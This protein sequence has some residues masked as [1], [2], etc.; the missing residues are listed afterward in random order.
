[1]TN[2]LARESH[3]THAIIIFFFFQI[4][5]A[6]NAYSVVWL[7]SAFIDIFIALLFQDKIEFFWQSS[8][9]FLDNCRWQ[10]SVYLEWICV[11]KNFKFCRILMNLHH[12]F[13]SFRVEKV[14]MNISTIHINLHSHFKAQIL[15]KKT[16]EITNWTEWNRKF[17][18]P[19][20]H[21]ILLRVS[22][23]FNFFCIYS[24]W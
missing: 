2:P 15:L 10:L 3:T 7:L 13:I 4:F 8:A 14:F 24:N 17:R 11:S 12:L 20:I 22:K 6:I 21:S 9:F 1:M 18:N 16:F 5:F 23:K 19:T